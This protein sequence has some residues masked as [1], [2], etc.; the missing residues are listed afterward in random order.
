VTAARL[1]RAIERVLDVWLGFAIAVMVGSMIW[2]VLGRYVFGHAPGWSEE[3][4]RFM[5][6]WVTMLGSAAALRAGGHLSV[7]TIVDTLPPRGVAV[8]LALRDAV[9]V[10]AAGLLVWQ[11]FLFARLNGVQESAAMEIPMTVPYAALP[12]GAALIL[13]MVLLSRVLGAPFAVQSTGRE[14]VF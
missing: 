10:G 12:A 14:G 5:M 13:V 6:L 1:A 4:S 3:L 8:V 11:G 7:T 9:V 2:Q